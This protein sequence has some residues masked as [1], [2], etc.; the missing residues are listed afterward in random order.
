MNIEKLL[1][2]AN[3]SQS[4]PNAEK[5]QTSKDK[6]SRSLDEVDNF[7]DNT[8]S[9]YS[10]PTE[11]DVPSCYSGSSEYEVPAK[12]KETSTESTKINLRIHCARQQ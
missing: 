5:E 1:V 3:S 8:D 4:E 11:E 7:E 10:M 12:K 9:T 6:A 2:Q